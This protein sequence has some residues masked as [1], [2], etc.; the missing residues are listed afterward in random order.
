MTSST[1][2]KNFEELKKKNLGQILSK[3]DWPTI[4]Q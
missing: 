3:L 1:L 2:K 4:P